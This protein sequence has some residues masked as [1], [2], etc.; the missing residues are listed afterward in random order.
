MERWWRLGGFVLLAALMTAAGSLAAEK[1]YVGAKTCGSC[2]E[3]E[4]KR[5]TSYAKKSHSFRAIEKM[6][7]EL[8]AAELNEC[9]AC[10]TTGYGKP[11]GFQ[12]AEATPDLKDAGC[13]VCHGPGSV[14]A[15][16]GAKEDICLKPGLQ[17]CEQCHTTTRVKAFNYRPLI[18]G[19]AH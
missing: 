8:T 6:R 14:H 11:G 3:E 2:H 19:G 13:E 5:F 7:S 15:E 16:T 18:Y 10:H 12:S 17:T 1:Q 9:Y 4:Y